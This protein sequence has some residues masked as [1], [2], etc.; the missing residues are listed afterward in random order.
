MTPSKT[1]DTFFDTYGNTN[2]DNVSDTW[3]VERPS[4]SNGTAYAD[5]DLDGDLD[6]IINN[7][8]ESR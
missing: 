2:F 8:N 7:I 3:V 1:F 5:L 4:Y 6:L